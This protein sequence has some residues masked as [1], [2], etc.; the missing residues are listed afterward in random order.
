MR[1]L[2]LLF[3]LNIS[4][5]ASANDAM[6]QYE[7]ALVYFTE[8][9]FSAAEIAVKNTLKQDVNYLPARLLLGEV[10][11]QTGRYKAAEKEFEQA[12]KLYADSLAFVIP[13]VKVKLFL[14]KNKQALVLL[15]KYPQLKNNGDYF[16]LQGKAYKEEQQFNEAL[17]AYKKALAIQGNSAELL[18]ALADLW[19]QQKQINQA[20]IQVNNALALQAD[21]IPALLLSIEIYKNLSEFEQAE[22]QVAFILT[23]DENNQQALFAKASLLLAKNEQVA[24]L[25]V[26]L[27]LRELFPNNPYAKL[28]HASIVA[29][30]GHDRQARRLLAD[31]KQQLSGIDDRYQSD[32]Q[33]LLL[34]ATVNFIN[35][36]TIKAKQKFLHYLELYG[37]NANARRYLAIIAF[38]QQN[39]NQAQRHI[40]KALVKN[41]NQSEF[42][43]LAAE[44]YAKSNLEEKKLTVLKKAWLNFPSDE[45]IK[46]QYIN[47]LLVED[48]F[49][50]ALVI[51]SKE[52]SETDANSSLQNSS[53]QNST[54]LAFMQ[55]E[56]GLLEQAKLTTQSLLNQYSDKIEVLQLAGELSLKTGQEQRAVYFFKQALILNEQFPAALLALAGMSLHRGDLVQTEQYYQQ[57]LN[58]NRDD[59]TVLQLYA[60]LAIKQENLALAIQL[61]QQI[62]TNDYQAGRA[63]VKLYISGQHYVKASELLSALEREFPLD[64]SLLLQK[65]QLHIQMKQP[66]LAKKTLKILFGLVY[67]DSDKLAVLAHYQLDLND[68]PAAEKTLARI[69]SIDA[70]GVSAL[71]QTRWH[72]M[73]GEYKAAEKIIK[74]Q[75]TQNSNSRV[76]LELKS[77]WLIAQQH[78]KKAI[79]IVK[80]IYLTQPLREATNTNQNHRETMQL[81]A[82]LYVKTGNVSQLKLLLTNWLAVI[83]ND[84]WSVAQLSSLLLRQGDKVQA[85]Q[86]IERFPRLNEQP[87]FLN[88]LANFYLDQDLSK[89]LSYA[90]KAYK[91]APNIAAIND[92]L[93]W[94]YYHND[95]P[96]KALALF[97]EATARDVNNGEIYYHLVLTLI[98]LDN[99]SQA[100]SMLNKAISLAPEHALRKVA[101]DKLASMNKM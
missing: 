66:F 18:T 3:L 20:R 63:L 84:A 73:K 35:S 50:L 100:K 83:P 36:N 46:Q 69:V 31:I 71:L 27:K 32:K 98:A 101:S 89:A 1:F 91:L 79:V 39:Y 4:F 99:K 28:L 56:Q 92:T 67:Q 49:D 10:L 97:R 57:L 14:H 6:T 29:Q 51:L 15:S 78:F 30:Q 94:L 64:Q 48:K 44:I 41:P 45:A 90:E 82:Q 93:G 19:Y 61:L 24:A 23:A 17:K 65:S 25:A 58:V 88:N 68:L 72:L 62:A 21:Y 55:L 7:K 2:L 43:I 16:F 8:G 33:V 12:Q 47:A 37:E 70:T 77:R 11:L 80:D 34:T 9:K 86:V 40:E 54:I 95:Q 22:S 85:I 87:L 13:L 53:L 26:V 74:E 59:K 96:S 81:L 5:Y 76:W 42:Y 75:L 60:D 52:T 38:R